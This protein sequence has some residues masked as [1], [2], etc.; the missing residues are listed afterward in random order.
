VIRGTVQTTA[1]TFL[2]MASCLSAFAQESG[3]LK[4]VVRTSSGGP[5]AGVT[6]IITNQVT[7]KVSRTRTNTDDSYSVSLQAGAYRINLDQPHTALFD[8]DKNYG[9]FAIARGDTLE[10]VIIE[11]EA[12]SSTATRKS[13]KHAHHYL[14]IIWQRRSRCAGS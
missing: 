7:R 9:D 8:K 11:P 10:N 12:A 1:L 14:R 13:H 6:V 3:R 4:G 2:I 5:A